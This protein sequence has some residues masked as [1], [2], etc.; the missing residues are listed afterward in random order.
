MMN[1]QSRKTLSDK[2]DKIMHFCQEQGYT[3]EETAYACM[4]AAACLG[5]PENKRILMS[6]FAHVVDE[7]E[8]REKG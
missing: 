6:F 5:G 1:K 8:E 3:E 2:T 4:L 7:N